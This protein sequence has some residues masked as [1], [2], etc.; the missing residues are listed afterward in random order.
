MNYPAPNANSV[1]VK[2]LCIKVMILRASVLSRCCWGMGVG[3]GPAQFGK[4]LQVI[5]ISHPPPGNQNYCSENTAVNDHQVTTWLSQNTICI[6]LY[7]L[8]AELTFLGDPFG[9]DTGRIN[10]KKKKTSF[11]SEHMILK[12]GFVLLH[13]LT[14][15]S[16]CFLPLPTTRSAPVSHCHSH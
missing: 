8:E 4:T 14:L 2:K 10:K 11:L 7:K 12:M 16:I 13:K 1:E 3:L 15:T 6:L 5:L 9:P